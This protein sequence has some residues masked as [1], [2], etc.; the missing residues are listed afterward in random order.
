MCI[1]GRIL[2]IPAES[3]CNKLRSQVNIQIQSDS[4][5]LIV[6]VRVIVQLVMPE[7]LHQLIVSHV[8]FQNMGL[9]FWNQ[10]INVFNSHRIVLKVVK[11][12]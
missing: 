11:V 6:R 2:G 1:T 5:S 4:T 8:R 7:N 12:R 10:P 9:G 3:E